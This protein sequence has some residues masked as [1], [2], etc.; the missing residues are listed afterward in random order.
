MKTKNK[1]APPAQEYWHVRNLCSLVRD[2]YF[3]FTGEMRQEA[4]G[5]GH[6]NPSLEI[7]KTLDLRGPFVV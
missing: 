2:V 5:P 4:A 6:I 3:T 1:G 7:C